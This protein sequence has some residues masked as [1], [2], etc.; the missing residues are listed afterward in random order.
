MASPVVHDHDVAGSEGGQEEL[1]YVEAEELAVDRAVE[2]P[3]RSD[4]MSAS[5]SL[6]LGR[7]FDF[8]L[9]G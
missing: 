1:F 3:G 5:A 4:G 7:H 6:T 8:S 2:Q 9:S